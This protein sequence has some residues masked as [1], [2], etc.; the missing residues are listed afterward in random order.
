MPPAGSC[1]LETANQ[2]LNGVIIEGYSLN[3][4]A[5]VNWSE[6]YAMM[7]VSA[8]ASSDDDDNASDYDDD[9]NDDE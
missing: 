3:W 9:D 7:V 4:T 5:T 1:Q 6:H 8:G 2:R